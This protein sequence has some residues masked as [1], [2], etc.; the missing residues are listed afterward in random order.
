MKEALSLSETSVLTR[1]TRRNIPEDTIL[2][3][4]HRENLRPYLPVSV[5]KALTRFSLLM[6]SEGHILLR[7]RQTRC[8]CR[9]VR[10]HTHATHTAEQSTGPCQ[11]NSVPTFV[12]RELSRGQRGGS[13]TAVNLTFLYRSRYS[14]LSSSSSF[15]FTRLSGPRSRPTATQKIW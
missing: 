4:H 6:H 1:A 7:T 14:F 12:D 2:H 3:S 13:P 15:I 8:P 10:H 11:R 9:A 5:T